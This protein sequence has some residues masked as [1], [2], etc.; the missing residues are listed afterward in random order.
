MSSAGARDLEKRPTHGSNRGQRMGKPT[1][2][3]AQFKQEIG[4]GKTD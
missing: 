4:N 1:P 3:R 2:F